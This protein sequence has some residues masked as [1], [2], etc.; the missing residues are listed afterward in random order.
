L[1]VQTAC[2]IVRLEAGQG[3]AS[4]ISYREARL[5][6]VSRQVIVEGAHFG[7][8]I[9]GRG[10]C[11]RLVDERGEPVASGRVSLLLASHLERDSSSNAILRES[12]GADHETCSTRQQTF[13]RMTA[14]QAEFG[15][16][17]DRYWFGGPPAV[18]DALAMLCL[19]LKLLSESDRTLSEVLDAAVAAE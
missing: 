13:E 3:P 6:A 10:E 8:W 18:P 14:N 15:N 16:D 17:G 2:R 5:Q 1:N 12:A 9:D 4:S 7:A 19:L 11:I